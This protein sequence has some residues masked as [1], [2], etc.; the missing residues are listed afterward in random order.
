MVTHSFQL[1][2]TVIGFRRDWFLSILLDK[3][4]KL[5]GE[6][7]IF[8]ASG[9]L[10][11]MAD[12]P[13]EFRALIKKNTRDE[14]NLSVGIRNKILSA[15]KQGRTRLLAPWDELTPRDIR[16]LEKCGM[17]VSESESD[18]DNYKISWDTY[19]FK[20]DQSYRCSIL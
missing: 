14:K 5:F 11:K 4:V 19:W 18:A 10:K 20:N 6:L 13:E 12:T 9:T 7:I 16:F 8:K 3:S 1:D 2:K 15:S 17:F